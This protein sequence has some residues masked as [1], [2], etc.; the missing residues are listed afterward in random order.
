LIGLAPL[1]PASANVG[2]G[3]LS[4]SSCRRSSPPALASAQLKLLKDVQSSFHAL[5]M[6]FGGAATDPVPAL[7]QQLL[8]LPIGLEVEGGDD[9]ISHE[10][11]GGPS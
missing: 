11:A 9:S 4:I 8:T 10:R 7:H 6:S 2:A 1:A 3:G 5:P